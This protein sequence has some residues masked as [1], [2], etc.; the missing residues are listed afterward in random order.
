MKL[1]K[2]RYF[3]VF[4]Q[5]QSSQ[6]HR[7]TSQPIRNLSLAIWTRLKVLLPTNKVISRLIRLWKTP[8]LWCGMSV[9]AWK[10]RLFLNID[11]INFKSTVLMSG[12][13]T[14][15]TNSTQSSKIS[16]RECTLIFLRM[17][18]PDIVLQRLIANMTSLN[19]FLFYITS[20]NCKSF[21]KVLKNLNTQNK[22]EPNL[23]TG[24]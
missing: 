11:P 19:H 4:N 22:M 24:H 15:L 10:F 9:V 16:N 12:K 3:K 18:K 14:N 21:R 5:S 13:N 23:G 1:S 17:S 8:R 20:R 2:N 7:T 6:S